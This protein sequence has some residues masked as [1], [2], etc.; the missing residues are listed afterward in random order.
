VVCSGAILSI[1]M[2]APDEISF[3]STIAAKLTPEEIEFM[4]SFEIDDGTGLLSLGEYIILM[5]VRMGALPPSVITLLN[6]KFKQL[7]VNDEG[8]ISYVDIV[9]GRRVSKL[10]A[11]PGMKP[12]D[13]STIVPEEFIAN[14]LMVNARNSTASRHGSAV[15]PAPV[16]AGPEIVLPP[17]MA[18]GSRRSLMNRRASLQVRRASIQIQATGSARGVLPFPQLQLMEE[19]RAGERKPD[20]QKHDEVGAQRSF[21]AWQEI[22][23]GDDVSSLSSS[24]RT[25]S[26]EDK[27][28]QT[29]KEEVKS[30]EDVHD[31]KGKVAMTINKSKSD[32]GADNKGNVAARI[33][34]SK[35]DGGERLRE[36]ILNNLLKAV[37]TGQWDDD[38]SDGAASSSEDEQETNEKQKQML[39][40]MYDDISSGSDEERLGDER[41]LVVATVPEIENEAPPTPSRK[42]Q[43]NSSRQTIQS[44]NRA[45]AIGVKQSGNNL[46]KASPQTDC[47]IE[48]METRPPD[49]TTT[50]ESS[51]LPTP[52]SLSKRDVKRVESMRKSQVLL[53]NSTQNMKRAE[54]IQRTQS[55]RKTRTKTSVRDMSDKIK[56]VGGNIYNCCVRCCFDTVIIVLGWRH[57]GKKTVISARREQIV[58]YHEVY[59]LFAS[60]SLCPGAVYLVCACSACCACRLRL[61]YYLIRAVWLLCG[62]WFYAVKKGISYY[63]GF[64]LR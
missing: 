39:S 8:R 61:T 2:E 3:Y 43:V 6:T 25:S 40:S 46:G 41:V 51:P 26:V 31:Y 36:S 56:K 44:T 42:G 37:E 14:S 28:I 15:A 21:V 11:L 17:D 23:E 12:P 27:D 53:G 30:K 38:N 22:P 57:P 7:D 55:F 59:L 48:D 35:S 32:G 54:S 63:K 45:T 34:K 16:L 10:L 62:A 49:S 64:Y 20:E 33:N 24:S 4:N 18:G 29:T 58:A 52:T 50:V 19:G 13:L 9:H 1:F 5:T 47:V 60:R